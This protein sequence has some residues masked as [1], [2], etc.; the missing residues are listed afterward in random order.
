[1][2]SRAA[3]FNRLVQVHLGLTEVQETD[4][5]LEDLEAESIDMVNLVA[6]IED[7][8]GVTIDD[9]DL[10]PVSTVRDL[11]NVVERS[12]SHE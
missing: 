8:Y 10:V 5:L 4:R 9:A 3:E 2:N 1:M 11:W 6:D 7:R 12:M